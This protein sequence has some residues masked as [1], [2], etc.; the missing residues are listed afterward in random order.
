MV[1]GEKLQDVGSAGGITKHTIYLGGCCP[2]PSREK[3]RGKNPDRGKTLEKPNRKPAQTQSKPYT[4]TQPRCDL[5][6]VHFY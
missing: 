3:T 2:T 1:P 6:K 5:G 4:N